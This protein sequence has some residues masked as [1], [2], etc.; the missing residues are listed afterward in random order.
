MKDVIKKHPTNPGDEHPFFNFDWQYVGLLIDSDPEGF[1]FLMEAT[2]E[3]HYMARRKIPGWLQESWGAAAIP[4]LIELLKDSQWMVSCAAAHEL[5]ELKDKRATDALIR[6][7]SGSDDFLRAGAAEALGDIGD[8][9]AIPELLKLLMKRNASIGSRI[10]A[11]GSLARMGRDEGLQHLRAILKTPNEYDRADTVEALGHIEISG[12]F[13]LL[14][15]LLNDSKYQVRASA[16][17]AL[18][19]LHDPRAIPAIRKLLHDP[20]A[21]VAEQAYRALDKLGDKPPVNT[22]PAGR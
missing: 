21:N 9:K 7:L 8:T 20:E 16:A 4:H 17:A 19:Q 11:A 3:C 14:L 13:D 2:K 15:P 12:A 22:Q 1:G 5:G 6:C 18:G 10:S